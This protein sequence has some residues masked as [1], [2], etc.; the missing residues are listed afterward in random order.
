MP[1]KNF[2]FSVG[3]YYLDDHPFF[4]DSNLVTLSTYTR[5]TDN[6]GFSSLHRYEVDDSTLEIQQ[7][8]VHRD[9]S[10]WTLAFGGVIRDN[11]QIDTDWGVVLSLTLKAFPKLALPIDIQPAN[12][13]GE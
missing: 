9:L 7:Y 1:T 11:R 5:L 6:W 3:S 4:P 10:S 8:Q 13:G 12:F 2:Q